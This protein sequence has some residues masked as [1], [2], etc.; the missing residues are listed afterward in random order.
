MT[1]GYTLIELVAVLLLVGV[2][3]ASTVVSLVP[4]A[5]G[6][7]HVRQS[8]RAMQKTRLAF[9]RLSQEFTAITNITASGP[10]NLDYEFIDPSGT[11]QPRTLAW[12]GAPGDDL[13][14]NGVPLTD[15]VAYF[16]LQYY[17]SGGP[18]QAVWSTNCQIIEMVLTNQA[19]R[20]GYTNRIAPRNLL[21]KG[22][23]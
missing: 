6:L 11:T 12:G 7:M 8:S 9:V 19:A 13:M 21:F 10:R 2:L 1:R 4:V 3:A 15:D 22:E 5:E 18:A 23:S 17:S 20:V 16:G 14:L